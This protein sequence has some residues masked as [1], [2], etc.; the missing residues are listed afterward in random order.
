MD[1]LIKDRSSWKAWFDSQE[2]VVSPRE[3]TWYERSLW[4]DVVMPILAN[5]QKVTTSM[6]MPYIEKLRQGVPLAYVCGRIYFFGLAFQVEPGVLIPRPETE[7]LV[8]WILEDHPA[9]KL[10]LLDIGSGSGVIPVTL[11][12]KRPEWNLYGMEKSN[13]AL[14]IS[15]RNEV[16]NRVIINWIHADLFDPTAL[17]HPTRMDVVV[18]NPPYIPLN[19]RPM[20]G[21][22]TLRYEPEEAL[23]VDGDDPLR[24][25]R[26]ILQV[27]ETTGAGWVYFELNEFLTGNYQNWVASCLGWEATFKLDMQGKTRMLRMIR[28]PV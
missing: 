8:A 11:K 5:G 3:V 23:F 13:D 15:K 7:E 24:F 14:Q 9:G 20:M 21:E 26:K 12:K 10:S 2:L 17:M 4:E 27:A 22:S 1:E 6:L 25:Y 18:S 16:L 19:E 28:K